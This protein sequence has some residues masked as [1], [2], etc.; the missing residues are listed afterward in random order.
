MIAGAQQPR[1]AG[2]HLQFPGAGG[3]RAPGH[4]AWRCRSTRRAR[5]RWGPSR[6]PRP[7]SRPAGPPTWRSRPGRMVL[8]VVAMPVTGPGGAL[9]DTPERRKKLENDL[10]DLYPV[11]KVNLRIRAPLV[12]AERMTASS[13]GFTAL[14]NARTEDAAKPWEYYHLLIG[15]AR[16]RP[17]ASPAWPAARGRRQR[18]QPPGGHHRDRMRAARRQHQH[19]RARD[20]PQPRPQPRPGLR[21]RRRRHDV[22]VHERGHGGERL[23][24]VRTNA[25]K[26]KA[27]FKELMGYC[28]PR[29]IS[30]YTWKMLEARVRAVSAIPAGRPARWRPCWTTDRCR[31]TPPWANGRR[32]AWSRATWW[33]PARAVRRHGEPADPGRRTTPSSPRSVQTA[34]RRR[35]PRTGREPA[36]RRG[37]AA[38]RDHRG[39]RDLHRRRRRAVGAELS[40]V[41]RQPSAAQPSATIGAR[42]ASLPLPLAGEVAASPPQSGR[43]DWGPRGAASEGSAR[44][45]GPSPRLSPAQT[46]Q[47]RARAIGERELG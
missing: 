45:A 34:V 19:R 35:H 41:S 20:R 32:G 2:D 23:L 29:W 27:R 14:R 16:S 10:Y 40:A 11:Q 33:T 3:R 6:P 46:S 4:A 36:G 24:A 26:S 12:I 22:P 30:D 25:L 5:R 7:G 44:S 9:M 17:S 38:R 1:A 47:T 39:R 8:D 13:A 18:R 15:P 31:P 42:S 21:R 37:G 43:P 28:R